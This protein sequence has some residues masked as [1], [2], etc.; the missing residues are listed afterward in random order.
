MNLFE[1]QRREH[2][3][4]MNAKRQMEISELLENKSISIEDRNK[5]IEE[6]NECGKWTGV[7]WD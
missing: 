6:A 7:Y 5:L 4:E 2:L 1:A 3:Y